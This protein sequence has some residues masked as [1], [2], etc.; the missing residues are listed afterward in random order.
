MSDKTKLEK[1]GPPPVP[2]AAK[3]QEA[4]AKVPF[5]LPSKVTSSPWDIESSAPAPQ[6]QAAPKT[7]WQGLPLAHGSHHDELEL[8]AAINQ[9]SSKMPKQQAEQKAY[10]DYKSAQHKAGAAHHLNGMKA[11]LASGQQDLARQ[12][13]AHYSSHVQQ[14]GLNP[15]DPVHPEINAM[16]GKPSKS[17][18]GFKAHGADALLGAK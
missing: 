5:D 17:L 4:Q 7:H 16:A 10:A 1:A 9:F 6:A 14:L 15:T 13:A 8:N 3:Q 18:G 2:N 11:A 12:H